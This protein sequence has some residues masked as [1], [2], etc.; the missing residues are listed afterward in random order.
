M[1][2]N[3]DE[4]ASTIDSPLLES[5]AIGCAAREMRSRR[6]WGYDPVGMTMYAY[7]SWGCRAM[8]FGA[9]NQ[10]ATSLNN[11]VFK[12]LRTPLESKSVAKAADKQCYR[13]ELEVQ[14]L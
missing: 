10:T 1:G 13:A 2:G 3:K 8:V 6:S 12:K 7:A 9:I 14:V 11:I 5:M 4:P